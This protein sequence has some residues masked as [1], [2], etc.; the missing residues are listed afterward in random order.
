M[1]IWI[2]KLAEE[3]KKLK[4][5][6]IWSCTTWGSHEFKPILTKRCFQNKRILLSSSITGSISVV[7]FNISFEK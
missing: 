3:A 1:T 7:A 5:Y 6:V 2:K 4:L